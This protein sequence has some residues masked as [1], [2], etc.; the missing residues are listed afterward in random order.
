M[1]FC[2]VGIPL[3]RKNNPTVIY[4]GKCVD[5]VLLKVLSRD[6]VVVI[7]FVDRLDF[8]SLEYLLPILGPVTVYRSLCSSVPAEILVSNEESI[9]SREVFFHKSVS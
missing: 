5:I 3:G 2:V 7:V 4:D 6:N 8:N 1:F 9:L